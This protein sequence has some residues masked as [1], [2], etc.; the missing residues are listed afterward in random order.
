MSTHSIFFKKQFKFD[1]IIDPDGCICISY[2]DQLISDGAW[3][4]FYLRNS[5]G[6]YQKKSYWWNNKLQCGWLFFWKK[7]IVRICQN[8]KLAFQNLYKVNTC[9]NV[10]EEMILKRWYNYPSLCSPSRKMTHK[11]IKYFSWWR[12]KCIGYGIF[13]W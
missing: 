8:L 10:L 13:A 11:R 3:Y 7:F 9:G 1:I 4:I 6:K 12:K 5:I 2:C